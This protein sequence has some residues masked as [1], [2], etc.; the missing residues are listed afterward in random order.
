MEKTKVLS[1]RIH[2]PQAREN[3]VVNNNTSRN[4]ESLRR[5]RG[6][7]TSFVQPPEWTGP[8][9]QYPP[10]NVPTSLNGTGM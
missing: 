5:I 4:S 7:Q 2:I 3:G 9:Q 1:R 8:R 10:L 6:T